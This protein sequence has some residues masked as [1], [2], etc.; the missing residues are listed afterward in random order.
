[1]AQAVSRQHLIAGV[2]VSPCRVG[3]VVDKVA[4]GKAVLL[5]SS[6]FPCQYH[7]TGAPYI[8]H[9]WDKQQTN[10]L[11][12]AVHRHSRPTTRT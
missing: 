8:Y 3:I 1:M 6:V 4:L 12:A 10:P 5:R 11:V 9:L 7:S 2:R